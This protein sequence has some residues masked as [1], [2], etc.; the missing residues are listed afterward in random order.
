MNTPI[1]IMLVEDHPE[2]REVIEM[3]LDQEPDLNLASQF[4]T[5]E[6]ALRS[7]QDNRLGNRID[8][9]LLDINLPGMSGLEALP[10][11]KKYVP[12]TRIILLTQSDMEADV[13][14]AISQGASGYLLKSST[15]QQIVDGIRVVI[16]GG[17]SLDSGVA[18]FI[19]KT[20][21]AKLSKDA[22]KVA[23]SERELE[24]LTLLAEGLSKKEIADRLKIGTT[25]VVTH[26]THIY[27]KLDVTSAPAAVNRAHRMGIFSDE[28]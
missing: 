19:L 12:E 14:Q 23:L 4:G 1:H 24:V 22:M 9:V 5:A 17:A 16:S 6:T 15:L 11:F 28:E 8:M 18:S 26:V 7:I 25:T 2:Y 13:L 27:E 21:K 20:L 10:W 3:A